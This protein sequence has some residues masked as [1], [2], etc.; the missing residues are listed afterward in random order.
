MKACPPCIVIS[1]MVATRLA[2]SALRFG[3]G[4]S[5]PESGDAFTKNVT[6]A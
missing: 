4:F 6:K 1:L 3:A 5:V 2:V